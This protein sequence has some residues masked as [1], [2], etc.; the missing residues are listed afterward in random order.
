MS[1]KRSTKAKKAARTR[2]LKATG[3]KAAKPRKRKATAKK[4]TA[5]KK[6]QAPAPAAPPAAAQAPE[7][8]KESEN[9][10]GKPTDKKQD[11]NPYTQEEYER[12]LA[13][14][15]VAL[16]YQKNLKEQL[17]HP[18]TLTEAEDVAYGLTETD[19]SE[20]EELRQK[21]AS[22]KSPK[23][24]NRRTKPGSQKTD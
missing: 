17:G 4:A 15:D 18:V 14:S 20:I 8:I 24:L 23:G 21:Y 13:H 2:K 16:A 3:K 11:D 10:D 5:T 6:L 7:I 9:I 19:V 12:D 22:A 1:T